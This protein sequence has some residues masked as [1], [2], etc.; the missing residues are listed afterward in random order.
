MG[1][2]LRI[3]PAIRLSIQ[4]QRI[5]SSLTQ[6]MKF[7]ARYVSLLQRYFHTTSH[8]RTVSLSLL[9]ATCRPSGLKHTDF[10]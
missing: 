2:L 9:D 3:N 6:T 1:D 5:A 8:S 4:Y 10:T 7:L